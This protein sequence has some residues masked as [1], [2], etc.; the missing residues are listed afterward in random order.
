MAFD[1]LLHD[2]KPC[3]DFL[4]LGII[5]EVPI[6]L[7]DVSVVTKV[8]STPETYHAF[9][10]VQLATIS[11]VTKGIK[12]IRLVSALLENCKGVKDIR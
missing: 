12:M 8:M 1:V 7:I 11:N 2:F 3:S 4:D 10:E 9:K 6:L 5:E